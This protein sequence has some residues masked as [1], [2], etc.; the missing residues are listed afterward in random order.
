MDSLFTI[1]D[2]P[3]YQPYIDKVTELGAIKILSLKWRNYAVFKCDSSLAEDI[4]DLD[5]VK[6]VQFTSSKLLPQ[7]YVV[8]S[9]NS[10]K[11]KMDSLLVP[12]SINEEQEIYGN[13]YEQV[14]LIGANYLH[15]LGITGDSVLISVMDS[16]F[17]WKD[18]NSLNNADV[19]YEY[20]FLQQDNTASDEKDD[21]PGQH[22]HGTLCFSSIAANYPG[23]LIGIAPHAKFI[24]CKTESVPLEI[25]LEEDNYAAAMEL[26][27]EI[28]AD[29]TTSSLA[30]LNF[31]E[32]EDSYSIDEL[33]GHSSVSSLALNGAVKR[34]IVCLTAA[35]NTGP[36]ARTLLT[37]GDADSSIT[38][39][40]VKKVAGFYQ[41]AGFTSRGPR[42]DSLVKPD[43]SA[44]GVKVACA[45]P[46]EPDKF[47]T[48]NGTSLA[49]PL[50]AGA[51]ALMLSSFPDL[52]P[53][54]VRKLLF[55]SSSLY[56]NKNNINGYGIISIVDA[57]K[58]AGNI[59][60]NP[61]I[62]DYDDYVR[63]SFNIIPKNTEK[64]EPKITL[65]YFNRKSYLFNLYN[66]E[67]INQYFCDIPKESMMQ[68]CIIYLDL[69]SDDRNRDK[70]NNDDRVNHDYKFN[71]IK[72]DRTKPG[73]FKKLDSIKFIGNNRV[74]IRNQDQKEAYIDIKFKN[75]N[76]SSIILSMLDY[77]GR[78]IFQET[79]SNRETGIVNFRLS[80]ANI[81]RGYYNINITNSKGTFSERILIK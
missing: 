75:T 52:K 66:E 68:N 15:S 76:T 27:D 81:S 4:A 19:I 3:L 5:F 8:D 64:I 79:K 55:S 1:E 30:Y 40:A 28:G 78:V 38:V 36:S 17:R 57:M 63:I 47:M 31:N 46:G 41:P 54:E 7:S 45:T 22:G 35:G 58:K 39:G 43:V 32:S 51:A 56:P 62:H 71:F 6:K 16:G 37:P 26:S 72:D 25:M 20:D 65:N 13:S 69:Q 48:A 73:L 74:I 14:N 42:A 60:S 33:D 59:I 18:H 80:T 23:K 11:F 21:T 34:G 49:T 29:I 53:W 77:S 50:V 2:A 44:L 10:H 12:L 70:Y 24:L 67:N 61:V 9:A